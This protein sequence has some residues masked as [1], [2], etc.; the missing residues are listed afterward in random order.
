M[1]TQKNDL[2]KL[3]D[4]LVE[5]KREYSRLAFDEED[6]SKLGPPATTQ[7]IA[8]LEKRLGKPLPPSYRAFLELHNGWEHFDG[9]ENLLSVED[10]NSDWVKECLKMVS[11]FYLAVDEE[12]REENPL[13]KGAIPILFGEGEPG[14]MILDPRK[15][16]KDGE[17]DFVKY[18]YAEETE[19]FKDFIS[20]LR[21]DLK[22]ER[23]LLNEEKK[24][25][26]ED[27][28]DDEDFG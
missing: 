8:K 12:E 15:V 20:F 24:G 27:E 19:R 2:A 18:E 26:R 11:M 5:I 17:M 16:R 22:V 10:Q 6:Q 1:K 21:N 9:G 28:D 3:I 4:Q 23:Q 25:T 13:E 14:Y 7:Q